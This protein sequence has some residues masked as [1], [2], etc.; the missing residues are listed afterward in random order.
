MNSNT[1]KKHVRHLKAFKYI[2]FWCFVAL[3]IL[4]FMLPSSSRPKVLNILV[5]CVTL[6]LL[7]PNLLLC[8]YYEWLWKYLI[9]DPC[10]RVVWLLGWEPQL[11]SQP[12][13]TWSGWNQ[14]WW[15]H[16][17]EAGTVS[18][19]QG[20]TPAISGKGRWTTQSSRPVWATVQ[21]SVLKIPFPW[22]RKEEK[23]KTLRPMR[24]QV[25]LNP[26][27]SVWKVE[28][29]TWPMPGK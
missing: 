16:A 26:F 5:L 25:N 19:G 9:G 24:Q 18:A 10:E 28:A 23:G 7:F 3:S 2:I 12:F 11:G 1:L 15:Q 21:D 14:Q 22:S 17:G 27:P 6:S 8:Y 4:I 29:K 13:A 20:F